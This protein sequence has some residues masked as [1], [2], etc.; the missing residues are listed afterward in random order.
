MKTLIQIVVLLFAQLFGNTQADDNSANEERIAPTKI[1]RGELPVMMYNAGKKYFHQDLYRLCEP[2]ENYI[3]DY[4]YTVKELQNTNQQIKDQESKLKRLD[5][6]LTNLREQGEDAKYELEKEY[7]N[8]ETQSLKKLKSQKEILLSTLERNE[9]NLL[10]CVYEKCME[11]D[12]HA[13]YKA[14]NSGYLVITD[15]DSIDESGAYTGETPPSW[16][17]SEF[18]V[19][20]FYYTPMSKVY[21]LTITKCKQCKQKSKEINE[22]I[23]DNYNKNMQLPDNLK[24]DNASE[25]D[26][27]AFR[28]Q[29]RNFVREVDK[30][31]AELRE[32]EK[33]CIKKDK[34]HGSVLPD[35]KKIRYYAA[36]GV[37]HVRSEDLRESINSGKEIFAANGIDGDFDSD[38]HD[39]G[40]RVILGFEVPLEN[41]SIVDVSVFFQD[42]ITIRGDVRGTAATVGGPFTFDSS[43]KQEIKTYGIDF[44]FLYRLT[45]SFFLGGG[46]GYH[47]FDIVDESNVVTTLNG[48]ITS[49]VASRDS[50][51]ESV[52][53]ATAKLRYNFGKRIFLGG[54]ISRTLEEVGFNDD[55]HVTSVNAHIGVRF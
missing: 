12:F 42:G 55:D 22:W 49:S 50:E 46:L 23:L 36:A 27:E 17:D 43:G 26:K 52:L 30:K 39:L 41:G 18:I 33:Q 9:N 7:F 20:D 3:D 8:Q 25:S 11:K 19:A 53:A 48:V 6:E 4:A 31:R 21:L 29:V 51:H 37:S 2:C 14:Y 54:D 1:T 15:G 44:S 34:S 47:F 24:V 5:E 45:P 35:K 13:K 16:L 38:S 40:H 28:N 32:C 10:K